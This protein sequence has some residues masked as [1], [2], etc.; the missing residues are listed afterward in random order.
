[1]QK[2]VF[3]LLGI[4]LLLGGGAP[5]LASGQ[6]RYTG[7]V[8][9]YTGSSDKP[10][11]R[12]IISAT[13]RDARMLRTG[14]DRSGVV[15]V[16]YTMNV[17]DL[18]TLEALMSDVRRYHAAYDP[19]SGPEAGHAATVAVMMA[20]AG[21][22]RAYDF[23]AGAGLTLLKALVHDSRQF[24]GLTGHIRRLEARIESLPRK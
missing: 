9:E 18:A 7:M 12:V 6:V 2:S 22:M 23:N 14:S 13:R 10:A 1:M 5:A 11:S 24:T 3:A 19:P 16:F 8:I 20:R 17:V 21:K 15:D 4:L